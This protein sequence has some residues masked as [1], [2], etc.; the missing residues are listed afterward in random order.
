[1]G[2]TTVRSGKRWRAHP[3]AADDPPS[4]SR[5]RLP[6][7]PDLDA[8][9]LALQDGSEPAFVQI[10]RAVHPGLLRYLTAMV[11]DSAE[12]VAQ[13]T[14]AQVCRDLHQFRGDGSAF[15]GW[16]TTI[17]RN[18]ALDHL[19][20]HRRRPVDPVPVETFAHVAGRQDTADQAVEALSTEATI[21]LIA[22]LPQDQ[23]EAVLLRTVMGL[24][25][26]RAGQVMSKRPGAVRTLAYRGLQTLAARIE[27][28]R[29]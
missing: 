20:A 13:E 18:R 23:A 25:A 14:W 24:D 5:S 26:K 1:L 9:V 10:Y 16:I 12:D 4:R 15:R 29:P 17:G 22:S 2:V 8:A 6:V 27:S 21:T 3:V 7:A 11:G 19:R 28:D